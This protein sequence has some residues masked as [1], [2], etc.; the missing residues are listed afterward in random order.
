MRQHGLPTG[1]SGPG[2]GQPSGTVRGTADGEYE[3][4][5]GGD[6]ANEVCVGMKE[7]KGIHSLAPSEYQRYTDN[8]QFMG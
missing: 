7:G 5:A 8:P 6:W 4:C 1:S 2:A 3:D